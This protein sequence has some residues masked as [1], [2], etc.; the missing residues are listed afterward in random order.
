MLKKLI[1]A[2]LAATMLFSV[3][4]TVHAEETLVERKTDTEALEA[5]TTT[6][7]VDE[8]TPPTEATEPT[9]SVSTAPTAAEDKGGGKL[10]EEELRLLFRRLTCGDDALYWDMF[11]E[12]PPE[13]D[14]AFEYYSKQYGERFADYLCR[15]AERDAPKRAEKTRDSFSKV[16]EAVGAD[17]GENTGAINWSISGTTLTITGS[18]VIPDYTMYLYTVPGEKA[19][20]ASQ[21]RSIKTIVIESGITEIGNYAFE[22]C[23]FVTSVT[24]PATVTRIGNNAFA[25]CD[26]LSSINLPTGLKEIGDNAFNWCSELPDIR[27]N[28][29]LERLGSSAFG[30]CQNITSA[31]F[32]EKLSAIGS[33]PFKG[34]ELIREFTLSSRNRHFTI[35]SDA[36]YDLE[37]VMLAYPSGKSI[38]TNFYI[39]SGTKAIADEVFYNMTI[40]NLYL[41]SSLISIGDHAFYYAGVESVDFSSCNQLEEIGANAFMFHHLS[42]VS[43]PESVTRIGDTAFEGDPQSPPKMSSLFIPKNVKSIGCEAFGWLPSLSAITVDSANPYYKSVNGVL[44]SKDGTLLH[45]YPSGKTAKTFTVPN[46]VVTIND[47]GFEMN[48]YLEKVTLPDSLRDIRWR[49]F[50]FCDKITTMEIPDSVVN[51]EIGCLNMEGLET[52]RFGTGCRVLYDDFI[53]GGVFA[54]NEKLRNVYFRGDVP[55]NFEKIFGEYA[56]SLDNQKITIFYPKNVSS[57]N[58]GNVYTGNSSVSFYPWDGVNYVRYSLKN[59][60]IKLS[61]SNFTYDGTAH[62][63]EATVT[64]SGETLVEG[65]DYSL[66]YSANTNAGS[67][68][69]TVTGIGNY[70]DTAQTSFTINKAKQSLTVTMDKASVRVGDFTEIHASGKGSI[71]YSIN[72]ASIATVYNTGVV[73]GEKKGT[74]RITVTANGT[75]N[76]EKAEK[77]VSLTVTGTMKTLTTTDLTYNFSNSASSFNYGTGY[78]IP[79]EAYRMFFSPIEAKAKFNSKGEWKGSCGGFVSS[80]L[81]FN[82]PYVTSLKIT[83]FRSSASRLSDLRVSDYSSKM[84]KNLK[85][86]IEAMQACQYYGVAGTDVARNSND[87]NALVKEVKRCQNGGLP[88]YIGVWRD[89]SGHALV[90]YRFQNYSSTE[91]RIYVYDCNH[92]YTERYL[93][94]YKSGSKYTGFYYNGGTYQYTKKL[95]FVSAITYEQMWQSRRTKDNT[96]SV[97]ASMEEQDSEAPYAID[98]VTLYVNSDN[99]AVYDASANKVAEMQNGELTASSS[100][101]YELVMPDAEQLKHELRLPT[102]EYT[103][104]SYDDP[105]ETQLE[106]TAVNANQSASVITQSD[107]VRFLVDDYQNTNLM[108]VAGHCGEKYAITFNGDNDYTI[109]KEK[110][111]YSGKSNGFPVTIG[112]VDGEYVDD[113]YTQTGIR[114]DETAINIPHRS[115]KTTENIANGYYSVQLAQSS[116]RFTG[117]PIEPSFTVVDYNGEVLSPNEHYKVAFVENTAPGTAHAEIYGVNEYYGCLTFDFS[118][119]TVSLSSCEVS[120]AYTECEATGEEIE[121]DVTVRYD[122]TDLAHDRFFSVSYKNNVAEGTASVTITGINGLTGQ[123]TLTFRIT[124]G[125]PHGDETSLFA[126][127]ERE[128]G[129]LEITKYLGTDTEITIPTVINGKTVT[130]LGSHLFDNQSNVEPSAITK[131]TLPDMIDT[132]GSYAFYQCDNLS[133]VNLPDS[134]VFVGRYAFYNCGMLNVFPLPKQLKTVEKGAFYSCKRE[135]QRVELP[136][137]LTTIGDYAFFDTVYRYGI[138]VPKSVTEIGALA[139]GFYNK[140]GKTRYLRSFP[141]Y[142]YTNT[143]AQQYAESNDLTFVPLDDVIG[144]VNQ[145]GDVNIRDVTAI[146]RSVAENESLS[147]EQLALADVNKDGAVTIDDATLLQRYLAEFDVVLW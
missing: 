117:E 50:E 111:V 21:W 133:S 24:L 65:R 126:Y 107:T 145:D 10:S 129:T 4:F 7:Y 62:K 105:Y 141:V 89:G 87:Y 20:W 18:G 53:G 74:A 91:D 147:S 98:E 90:G 72:D 122:G 71:R 11:R 67:A 119:S 99:F 61:K 103:V 83:D 108:N 39:P 13:K 15:L 76:Y 30:N 44:Y 95:S 128:D 41:P 96:G 81:L 37:G 73:W 35:K 120:L 136:S 142:G 86:F 32:G 94:L 27:L 131:V 100:S 115:K 68:K 56:Y 9:V 135:E 93:S 102:S 23:Y 124:R 52:V 6:A 33:S 118:I 114:E 82:S 57:W 8:T 66:S 47:Y 45:T 36:L 77:T 12:Y 112:T 144:D 38:G 26:R 70:K 80:S 19:P 137:G 88:V 134:V 16:M 60:S 40:K 78:K 85:E 48:D 58:N 97:G 121:P 123:K 69:V 116:F 130:A 34:C 22:S 43:I 49:A 127:S 51:L 29:N 31:Y 104:K 55:Q 79:E 59:A 1:A 109:D 75:D 143:A 54:S 25:N 92:P 106:I 3:N 84:G 125:S 140:D 101:V 17:A 2:M 138:T 46:T 14:G 139:F 28:D 132:I 5:K 146:Q 63:P 110:A 113:N 64:L 42:S